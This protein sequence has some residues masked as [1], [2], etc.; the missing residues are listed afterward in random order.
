MIGNDSIAVIGNPLGNPVVTSASLK[1]PGLVI[2]SK[3]NAIGFAGSVFGNQLAKSL[4]PFAS[5]LDV[6]QNNRNHGLFV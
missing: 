3:Q 4:H 5:S 1:I 6:W 2:V